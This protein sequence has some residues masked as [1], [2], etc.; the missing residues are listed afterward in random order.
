MKV[1][2]WKKLGHAN[3]N[4]KKTGMVLLTSEKVGFQIKAMTKDREEYFINI[5]E[6]SVHQKDIEILNVCT[7]KQS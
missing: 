3:L 1:K 5:L 4:Q 2:V 7:K 6:R